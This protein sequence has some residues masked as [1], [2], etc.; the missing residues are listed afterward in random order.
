M[1]VFDK[2]RV[3]LLYQLI[4]QEIGEN[5][6]MRDFDALNSAMASIYETDAHGKDLHPTIEQKA[7]CL[8]YHL[9]TSRPFASGNTCTG[10]YVLLTMLEANGIHSSADSAEILRLGKAVESGE[11]TYKQL[12]DWIYDHEKFD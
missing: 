9:I 4:S 10:M 1:I 3:L 5:A 7:A 2:K 6:S 8:A 11:M 12:L